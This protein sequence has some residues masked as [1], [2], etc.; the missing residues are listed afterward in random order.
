M[1][2]PATDIEYLVAA[3]RLRASTPELERAVMC[4]PTIDHALYGETAA[5]ATSRDQLVAA[6]RSLASSLEALRASAAQCDAYASG[7]RDYYAAYRRYLALRSA[8]DTAWQSYNAAHA[9][10]ASRVNTPIVVGP[11]VPGGAA[12][13]AA[14][15][16][17]EPEP[18]MPTLAVPV[19]PICPPYCDPS[20]VR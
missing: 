3:H 20:P 17:V 16:V 4:W 8:Y 6:Q 18:S 5:R 1:A 12:A 13:T 7:C 14:V 10:W 19:E 9:S 2:G 15:V 11:P